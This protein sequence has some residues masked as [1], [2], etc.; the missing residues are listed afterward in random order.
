VT[1]SP[2]ARAGAPA[3]RRTAAAPVTPQPP[4][5]A[6]RAFVYSVL[7]PGLGQSRLDRQTAGALFVAVE[8]GVLTMARKA[9]LDLRTA[10]RLR[11]D[12]VALSYPIDP[13]TGQPGTPTR[14]PGIFTQDLVRARQLHYEDWI[15][16]LLF[17]HIFAGAEA[18]VAANLW[19]LPT[20]VTARPAPDGR[21]TVLAVRVAW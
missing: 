18:F 3:R 10:K 1:E 21:G 9:L 2:A 14:G 20:Q 8:A 6:R 19:D 4:I 5:S 12:T 7:V 11:A 15:A 17:N 16:L 13:V